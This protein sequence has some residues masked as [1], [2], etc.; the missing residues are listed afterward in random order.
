MLRYRLL[1]ILLILVASASLV[2]AENMTL[3]YLYRYNCQPGVDH[4]MT[5]LA[6][7]SNRAIIAGYPALALVDLNALP[8]GGAQSYLSRITGHNA[9]NVYLY[10]NYV[11]V[12]EHAMGSP[13]ATAYGFSVVRINGDVLQD[14]VRVYETGALLEKMCISG[15]YLYVTAHNKGIRVYD[16]SNPASPVKVGSLTSGFTDAFDIAV[17]GSTAY[18]ADGAGGLKIV[19]VTDPRNPSLIGGEDLT[20]SAGTAEAIAVRNGKVYMLVGSSGMAV[21]DGSD[22]GSRR[23]ISTNGF[24]EDL[25]WVGDYLAVSTYPGI[26]V[27]DVSGGSPVLVASDNS[28]RRGSAG[29]L[30]ICCGVGSVDNNR[31]MVA[32]WNYTDIYQLKPASQSTQPDISGTEQRI[33]FPASRT[34]QMVTLTNNGQGNLNITSVTAPSGISANYTGG[35]LTP[36]Q[37]TTFGVTYN[38][39]S[40]VSGVVQ[41]ASNDPDENPLPIQVFARTS[42]L[43]PGEPAVDFTLPLMSRNPQTGQWSQSSFTLSQQRGKVVYFNV[44]ASW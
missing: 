34:T 14:V 29:A 22:L 35:T 37:S 28:N 41:F 5:A 33:R 20:T 32:D 25:A 4:L 6:V 9:R 13:G 15:T 12:N 40:A 27:F 31:I 17:S 38:G 43:D 19:D 36:G 26:R 10:G 18:V 30:R 42:N 44:Y 7:S 16:I 8:V 24:A 3:D 23:I 11:F 21:Y 2:S 1:L 39:A